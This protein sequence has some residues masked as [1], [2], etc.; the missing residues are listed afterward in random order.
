MKGELSPHS[1]PLSFLPWKQFE[2]IVEVVWIHDLVSYLI[3]LIITLMEHSLF[4]NHIRKQNFSDLLDSFACFSWLY[5]SDR[6]LRVT[7]TVI[8]MSVWSPTYSSLDRYWYSGESTQIYN[9]KRCSRI[10]T[11]I[12]FSCCVLRIVSLYKDL[13]YTLWFYSKH[14]QTRSCCL[15]SVLCGE[16][17]SWGNRWRQGRLGVCVCVAGPGGREPRGRIIYPARE[18]EAGE[19]PRPAS[20]Y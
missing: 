18:A 2:T 4:I 10:L 11:F 8:G 16:W 6:Y 9:R 5:L 20:R 15:T 12:T 14:K 13:N 3:T 19:E 7:A 1:L 17:W